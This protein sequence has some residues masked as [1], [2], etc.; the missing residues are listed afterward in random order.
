MSPKTANAKAESAARAA[1][2]LDDS[3]AEAHAVK[4]AVHHDRWEWTQADGAYRQAIAL[5]PT[6]ATT[7][8]W[9]AEH[10]LDRRRV[11]DAIAEAA[12]ARELEPLSL[13]I[14]ALHGYVHVFGAHDYESAIALVQKALELERRLRD[15]AEAAQPRPNIQQLREQAR[16][17]GPAPLFR[18]NEILP[19]IEFNNASVRDILTQIGMQA[20][21]N[22]T[23]ERDFQER[24][25]APGQQ[26]YSVQLDNVTLEQALNQVVQANEL[27][28]KVLDQKTIMVIND[29]QAKRLAHEDQ[30]IKVLRVSHA[31]AT[32]L[33]GGGRARGR[34]LARSTGD[35]AV[36]VRAARRGMD[37]RPGGCGGHR[38][39]RVR[40]ARRDREGSR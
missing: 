36:P 22:V 38:R 24:A 6:Y 21:I 31:D 18:L 13:P 20:G 17:A 14:N 26:G 10:L 11:S 12:R 30:V 8:Q 34:G 16:R 28:Y 19:A 4:A 23:F 3:I 40:G 9:Y 15:Q 2:A 1:L 7:H 5:S 39:C 32:D 33:V 27:F 29:T 37:R 35:R 25:G